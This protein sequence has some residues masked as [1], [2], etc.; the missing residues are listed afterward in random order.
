MTDSIEC[1]VIGAA[2]SSRNSEVIHAAQIP[3]LH[4][5]W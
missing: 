1:V 3:A 2:I 5:A 4:R